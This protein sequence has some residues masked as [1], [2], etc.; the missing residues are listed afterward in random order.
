MSL[1]PGSAAGD[2]VR[3]GPGQP[4]V[5]GSIMKASF[6]VGGQPVLCTDSFVN[7]A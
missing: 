3:Y 7:L 5:E 1:I 4:G 2:V 6:T